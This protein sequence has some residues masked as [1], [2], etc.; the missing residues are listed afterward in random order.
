MAE[1]IPITRLT[2]KDTETG[3]ETPVDVKTC[4]RAVVCDENKTVQ[5]HVAALAAHLANKTNPHGVT[6]AQVGADPSGSAA[7]VQKNLTDHK[8]DKENPHE[9]TKAQVGLGNV[10]NT[11]DLDKP[12]STAQAAAIADAKKAGTDAAEALATHKNDKDNP[13][14]VTAAQLSDFDSKAGA[15][16]QAFANRIVNASSADT[17]YTELKFRGVSLNSAEATPA[18]NGAI[19]WQYE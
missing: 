15:I 13:H 18:V 2:V 9:V 10:D 1:T 4:A 6:A 5:D 3:E 14:G 19:A 17:G 7:A 12:V 11:A 16:V 8:N